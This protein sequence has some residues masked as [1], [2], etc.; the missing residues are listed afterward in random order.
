MKRLFSIIGVFAATAAL[1]LSS[2]LPAQAVSTGPEKDDFLSTFAYSQL[3]PNAEPPG[4]NDWSCKPSAQNPRPVVLAH[5]TFSN[6]Y[7]DWSKLAPALKS[8]GYCV[9]SLNYGNDNKSVAS[10]PPGVNGT[11]DIAESAR[12]FGAFVDKVLAATGAAKVD[13]VGYSQGGMMPRQY[14][15]FEGGATKV[16]NLVGIAPTNNGST[17]LG[18]SKLVSI[19]NR[20]G[21]TQAI[22]GKAIAQW[23]AGSD[24][25]ATLNAGGDT[26]PGVNYTVIATK[27]D[28]V[29]TPYQS[30][31]L[32][33]GPGA[34][35]NNITLQNG[36]STDFSDHLNI[37]NSP[38]TMYFV[39]KALNPQ[40]R[41]GIFD[42]APCTIRPPS[43]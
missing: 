12:E 21:V 6:Q 27:Y 18:T 19:F 29:V 17:L 39:Q 1:V 9:Y 30:A 42:I 38:R 8:S 32:K 33:A 37:V 13:V 25:V 11:G 24:F 40:Y 36:C 26:L 20:F 16:Q 15:K 2:G 4:S 43:I 31:F 34:K 14:M 22:A 5:G 41:N 28:Q 35:V 3:H 10:T 23:T 7:A